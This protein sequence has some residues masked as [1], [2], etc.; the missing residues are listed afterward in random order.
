MAWNNK[1]SADVNGRIDSHE[2][3]LVE[4]SGVAVFGK[5]QLLDI[6]R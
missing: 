3:R 4:W 1:D 2:K 6:G 5:V